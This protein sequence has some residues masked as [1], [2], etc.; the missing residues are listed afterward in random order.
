MADSDD[1]ISCPSCGSRMVAGWLAMWNPILGQKVRW[2]PTKPAYGRWRVPKGAAVVLKARLGGR[3]ARSAFRCPA[4]ATI[5][6]S[7]SE[8]YDR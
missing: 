6:I 7:P 4:C 1:L 5:V 3:D 2:Q 8:S